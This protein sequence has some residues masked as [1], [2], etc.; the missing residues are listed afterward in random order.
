LLKSSGKIFA[1]IEW[2]DRFLQ[3]THR[4][5]F[6]KIEWKDTSKIQAKTPHRKYKQK[7]HRK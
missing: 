4:K 3:A 7:P 1:K 5:I 6:A 2:K